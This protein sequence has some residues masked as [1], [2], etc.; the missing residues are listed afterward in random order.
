MGPSEMA[1]FAV[2]MTTYNAGLRC[3][4]HEQICHHGFLGDLRILNPERPAFGTM[5]GVAS[6]RFH[7][8]IEQKALCLFKFVGWD[9]QPDSRI[10]FRNEP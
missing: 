2:V 6:F 3:K 1:F 5:N 10:I 8:R 4:A 9:L 7:V